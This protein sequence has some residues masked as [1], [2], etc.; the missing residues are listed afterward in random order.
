MTQIPLQFRALD[1]E[2]VID[3]PNDQLH[4][5]YKNGVQVAEVGIKDGSIFFESNGKR[6]PF[7]DIETLMLHVVCEFGDNVNPETYAE[8]A[9]RMLQPMINKALEV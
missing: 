9:V 5:V 3:K 7:A 2:H 6:L 1:F 8:R 4:R